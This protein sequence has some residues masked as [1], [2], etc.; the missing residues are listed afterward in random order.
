[1]GSLITIEPSAAVDVIGGV[2][3]DIPILD[4]EAS[5]NAT[6]CLAILNHL[7]MFAVDDITNMT[8]VPL[9]MGACTKVLSLLALLVHKYKY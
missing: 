2:V 9:L 7:Q 3:L 4:Q 8:E 5:T 6:K 1:M